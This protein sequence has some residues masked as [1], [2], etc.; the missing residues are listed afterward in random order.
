MDLEV[1]P[2]LLG[3]IEKEYDA[4]DNKIS[5]SGSNPNPNVSYAI[6]ILTTFDRKMRQKLESENALLK[7]KNEQ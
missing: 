4:S 5:Q 1:L 2:H 6:H 7:A 3:W